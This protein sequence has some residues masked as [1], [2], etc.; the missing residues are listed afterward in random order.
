MTTI[1]LK[2]LPVQH[3]VWEAQVVTVPPIPS[4]EQVTPTAST[5]LAT[6]TPNRPNI[7]CTIP[8]NAFGCWSWLQHCTVPDEQ[9]VPVAESNDLSLTLLRTWVQICAHQVYFEQHKIWR[10]LLVVCSE[11]YCL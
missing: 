10:K 2:L 9:L 4:V 7:V 3:A 6:L 8:L 11:S 5:R 1:P